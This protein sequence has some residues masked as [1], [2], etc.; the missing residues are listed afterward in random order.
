MKTESFFPLIDH[1]TFHAQ[2]EEHIE[3]AAS[4]PQW[5]QGDATITNSVFSGGANILIKTVGALVFEGNEV[6]DNSLDFRYV[7]HVQIN[8]NLFTAPATLLEH[9]ESQTTFFG[10][11]VSGNIFQGF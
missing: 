8:N 11:L 9:Q 6:Y 5:V 7:S 2:F 1:C 4:E 3:T 10:G